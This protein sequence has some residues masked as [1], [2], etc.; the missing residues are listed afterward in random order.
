[1]LS[2]L[3][4]SPFCMSVNHKNKNSP[5]SHDWYIWNTPF[6]RDAW[7][8]NSSTGKILIL[9]D[10]LF[11][12]ST[13]LFLSHHTYVA[14]K[15]LR[16]WVKETLRFAFNRKCASAHWNGHL[17]K[18]VEMIYLTSSKLDLQSSGVATAP[19]VSQ[20]QLD[21]SKQRKAPSGPK[22]LSL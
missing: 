3:K 10:L 11:F 7:A 20:E 1:M 16:P 6:Q 12:S 21:A 15:L 5:D 2:R 14:Q 22:E 18:N 4:P 9:Q 17:S 8:N 19:S 13:K